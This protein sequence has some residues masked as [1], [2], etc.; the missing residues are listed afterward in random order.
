M[1]DYMQTDRSGRSNTSAEAE[2]II[3]PEA[4]DVVSSPPS[5]SRI[6]NFIRDHYTP[7]LLRPP[8]KALVL[9]IFGAA[10][11]SAGFRLQNLKKGLE[12][13]DWLPSD[14]YLVDFYRVAR[15]QLPI[16]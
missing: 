12:M 7:L 9:L 10:V 11:V 3:P 13:D 5:S 6:R 4:E 8:A 1:T 14:S 2:D 16:S 15:P